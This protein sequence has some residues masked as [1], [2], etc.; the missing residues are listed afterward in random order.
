MMSGRALGAGRLPAAVTT[1]EAGTVPTAVTT[2]DAGTVPMAVT[3]AEAGTVP[4]AVTTATT[5]EGAIAKLPQSR[6]GDVV[7]CGSSFQAARTQ[8]FTAALGLAPH[9]PT[10]LPGSGRGVGAGGPGYLGS[11]PGSGGGIQL[12]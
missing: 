7:A 1:A 8:P 9:G 6:P 2:A 10:A 4:M 5:A 12:F 11:L 3:T